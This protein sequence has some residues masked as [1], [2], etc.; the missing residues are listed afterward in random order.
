MCTSIATPFA[1]L[2]AKLVGGGIGFAV[3]TDCVT[4]L[5]TPKESYWAMK[6]LYTPPDG[7][8]RACPLKFVSWLKR[9]VTTILSLLSTATAFASST[10]SL[11]PSRIAHMIDPV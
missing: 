11:I 10:P 4:Q 6:T 1:L 9:P 5:S 8:V 2:D 7:V 3:M